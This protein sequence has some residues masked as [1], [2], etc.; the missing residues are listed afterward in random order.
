MLEGIVVVVWSVPRF[1]EK[2]TRGPEGSGTLPESKHLRVE[3]AEGPCLQNRKGEGSG[4]TPP[5]RTQPS[6]I[7][8]SQELRHDR[9]WGEPPPTALFAESGFLAVDRG[10]WHRHRDVGDEGRKGSR[11]SRW[12][13]RPK[14][15]PELLE[16]RLLLVGAG[17]GEGGWG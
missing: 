1:D 4:E 15:F 2:G 13:R 8:S 5:L 6:A 12:E 9:A 11:E 14:T 16:A 10:S 7:L 17:P 3:T